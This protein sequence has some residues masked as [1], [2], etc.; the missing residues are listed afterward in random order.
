M[1]VNSKPKYDELIYDYFQWRIKPFYHRIVIFDEY[2]DNLEHF[3][4]NSPIKKH[5]LQNRNRIRKLDQI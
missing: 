5:D 2:S 1:V 3:D 4:V